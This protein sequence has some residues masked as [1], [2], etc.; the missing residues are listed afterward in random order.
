[1][2]CG[3]SR[4]KRASSCKVTSTHSCYSLELGFSLSTYE[5]PYVTINLWISADH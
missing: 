1:M 4:S 3:R 2:V 5:F